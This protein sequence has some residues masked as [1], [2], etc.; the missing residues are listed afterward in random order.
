MGHHGESL[1]VDAEEEFV[2]MSGC[3]EEGELMTCC[4]WAFS[5]ASV[6]VWC[7]FRLSVVSSGCFVALSLFLRMV[8]ACDFAYYCCCLDAWLCGFP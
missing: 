8:L 6:R 2:G 1:E 4:G 7:C 5:D 3:P